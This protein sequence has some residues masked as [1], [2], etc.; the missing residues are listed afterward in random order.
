MCVTTKPISFFV[1]TLLSRSQRLLFQSV[2]SQLWQHDDVTAKKIKHREKSVL[3]LI[4][5]P[6]G[7]FNYNKADG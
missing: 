2:T 1:V 3:S 6:Y 5:I 7:A 4:F